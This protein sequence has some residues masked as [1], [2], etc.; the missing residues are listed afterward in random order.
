MLPSLGAGQLIARGRRE[1]HASSDHHRPRPGLGQGGGRR[2]QHR[3]CRGT[4]TTPSPLLVVPGSALSVARVM[5]AQVPASTAMPVAAATS[6]LRN[7]AT[8]ASSCNGT[9]K[10]RTVRATVLPSLLLIQPS[11]S[12]PKA[13]LATA[14][15]TN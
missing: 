3:R 5:A 13:K 12:A 4:E 9:V 2:D 15:P 1:P 14:S 10:N 7:P 6:A 8:L 11:W